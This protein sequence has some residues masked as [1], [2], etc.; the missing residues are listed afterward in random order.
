MEQQQPPNLHWEVFYL[1]TICYPIA[2][3]ACHALSPYLQLP[4]IL[5][6]MHQLKHWLFT[7]LLIASFTT[8]AQTP[9]N[10]QAQAGYTYTETFA[11]INN[12]TFAASDG[13]FT[14]GI[15]ASAWRGMDV[16]TSTPA[17]PNATRITTLSNFFQTPS[18]SGGVPIYSGGVYRGS[19]SLILL[20][21]GAT[22]NTSSIAMDF[23]LNFSTLNAGMLSFDWSSLN[24]NTGNRNS[25][26]KVYASTDGTTFTEIVAAQVLNFTNNSPT[27]GS[28]TNV[29]LPSI[30][31]GSATARLRFYYYNATGGT[32][33]SRPRLNLDNIKV[34]AVPT[35][36]C[37][38]PSAQPTNF[39]ANTV[40]NNSIQ[41]SFTA[42]SPAPQNYL[43]VQSTN[44]TLSSFPI[45]G[46]VY[47]IGDN[48]GDGTVIA[49]TNSTSVTATGLTNSTT[50]RFFIF[51]MNNVC[52]GGP[53]YVSNNPLTG[54]A[55]TLA[56]P[57]PCAAPTAQPTALSFS[58]IT[59]SS[60]TG[61]FTAAANTDEYLIVRTTSPTFTG[62]LNNG[63]TYSGG[64]VLGNGSVV[65]RTTGT[66]FTASNLASGTQYYFFVFGLNSQNCNGGPTY[67][68]NNPLT[69]NATT[70]TLPTCVAP[71][72]QP[73]LLNL[74]ASNTIINGYFT[75]NTSA[76]G[77]LV[78]RSTS[79]SLS[80][81]PVNGN[82][83]A[84]GVTIGNGTVVANAASTSFVDINLSASTPYFYFV[85][86]RNANCTG[87]SPQ[88]LT[89][90]P[91]TG[92]ATTTATATRNF[93]FGNLHAH[94]SYS[95]GN[96]D[97][98]GFTPANNYA[99]AKNSLCMDFL[100]ISEH[101]H[102]TAGMSLSNWPLGLS[103]ATAATNS[104]FLALYG[105]EY[106]VISN[107]GHV[108]VYGSNQLF[109]WE[110]GNYNIYIPKSDYIGT[111]ETTGTTGL[112]RTINNLNVAGGTV[113]SS[114]AHPDF[115]DYNN[116]ANIPFNATADSALVGCAVASGPAFSTSTTYNDPP[117]SMGYLDYYMKM[118]S[119]GYHIGPLMD[120]DSHNT[121]FGRSS[122]NRLAFVAPT[123]TS[124]NF[125]TAMKSRN[126]YATEDCDTRVTLTVNNQLMGSI[127]TGT[128]APAISVYAT[129][130]TSPSSTPTIRL[131]Y[132][133]A[134]SGVLPVQVA[135]TTG[136]T[137]NYTDNLLGIN[138]NAYYYADITINGNRTIT[139]PVWYTKN[140]AVP[141]SLT[142]FGATL[143]NDRSVL[144]QWTTSREINNK[145]FEVERS[146]DGVNFT[147]IGNL[148]AVG[149]SSTQQQYAYKD[150]QPFDGIN[151]YRLK[152]IDN[153]G[154]FTYSNI[155]A[156]NLKK[157]AINALAIYPNP[158]HN[159]LG[160]NI[161]SKQTELV[162]VM[163]SDM[164]GQLVKQQT[165]NL[166]KGAQ[167]IWQ[168][169]TSLSKGTYQV[170]VIWA[171]G[172]ITRPVVKL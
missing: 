151:Y 13:T 136:N 156:L 60:I 38:T 44:T 1:V 95:D 154:H 115:S 17:I 103:Q 11:D 27:A 50:Y 107:G 78:V 158:T 57:L 6:P 155:V 92:N 93:Y 42:A 104:S 35:T 79:N 12:W 172:S 129:D 163:V 110:S 8:Q 20:S 101:N 32:S 68:S 91:L 46:T 45:N 9:I 162:K 165:V 30:F 28:I 116:L 170:T 161:N 75:A 111:P 40:I 43:V 119:K 48:L 77:Y 98:A 125:Y 81:N 63:T 132:G 41:F 114:F 59:T 64:N 84:V 97:N 113:F 124:G 147:T 88:Y 108:L 7:C 148:P 58:N 168:D 144:V 89:T 157:E 117:T 100:G 123:L 134:G 16:T 121:N 139:A 135:L 31:N 22:D 82:N 153:N 143:Q 74:S 127:V 159:L 109:G 71:S 55:T 169:I 130:P 72:G 102:A 138:A 37:S 112:F 171:D 86:A 90:S 53:L 106:G 56:G 96:Q 3:F 133:I 137:L 10:M 128:I 52:T 70:I 23:Y 87:T 47:N 19:Q 131:M 164:A 2:L 51:S 160:L 33:G 61:N 21:T 118:L 94:S 25:S 62:T 105:M 67:N 80:S 142:R 145:Y 29:A 167:I 140:N 65:T 149:N 69:G 18:S 141:I 15:G 5:T 99:Y 150:A 49:V 39:V 36:P 122:N 34:T 126:F 24:N 4:K 152:Q 73:T 54:T 83:Y 66:S 26:L 166:T 120:H 14:A 146:T 76:D 85:F